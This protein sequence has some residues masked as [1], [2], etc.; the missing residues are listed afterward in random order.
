M[1]KHFDLKMTNYKCGREQNKAIKEKMTNLFNQAPYNS[2]ISLNIDYS[3]AE[4]AF[5]GKLKVF[6]DKKIFF[7]RETEKMIP[8]LISSLCKK[9]RKQMMKWK[10]TR[11][12]EEIT[13]IIDLS[14]YSHRAAARSLPEAKS[15][16]KT[17]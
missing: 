3:E 11:T 5:H 15:L 12:Y 16:K 2:R 7:A 10:E 9:A 17:G 14:K 1:L 8:G 13:G 4:K 6:S